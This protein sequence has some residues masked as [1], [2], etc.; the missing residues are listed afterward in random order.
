MASALGAGDDLQGF[1]LG[2]L[3]GA[4]GADVVL[5]ALAHL[6]AHLL[7]QVAAAVADG[8]AGGTAGAGGHG[9]GVILV[10][11]IAE[12]FVGVDAGQVLDGAFHGDHAHQA[13]A[14]GDQGGHGLHADA[15]VLLKGLAHFRMGVQ[16]LL[17]VHQHLHDA[18][19]EDLHEVHV[20]TQLLVIGAAED[21]DPGQVLGQLLHLFHGLA[22][23]LGQ[24]LYGALLAQAC[25]DGNV[26]L[27]VSDDAGQ[28]IVLGGVLVDLVH[29]AGQAADDMTEL[30][31]FRS[32]FSHDMFLSLKNVIQFSKRKNARL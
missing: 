8:G 12:L 32:Q 14:V 4:A 19:G 10:Q 21:A 28:G 3:A 2:D 24:V 6:D 13:V 27:I 31:D 25:R 9:E 15:G 23:L 22:D 1:F 16:Q 18:G 30:D 11:I 5:R 7:G 17:V 20:F 29:N 26:G